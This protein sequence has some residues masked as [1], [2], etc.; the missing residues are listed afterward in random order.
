MKDST[1]D[2]MSSIE[3]K[4]IVDK[5]LTP[6]EDKVDKEVEEVRESVK[7]VKDTLILVAKRLKQQASDNMDE[8]N[9]LRKMSLGPHSLPP[10][11]AGVIKEVVSDVN[12]L[13][14]RMDNVDDKLS[15]MDLKGD[16]IKFHNLGFPSKIES[17]AWLEI[18]SPNG[19]FGLIVDFHTLMGHIHHSITG[20]DALK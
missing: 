2:F 20:V 12:V 14:D 3:I 17:D 19:T 8:I 7:S 11:S 1:S 9:M 15:R 6:L 4:R 10:A 16:S 13:L 5:N 18:H